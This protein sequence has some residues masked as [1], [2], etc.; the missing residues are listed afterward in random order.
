MCVCVCV[1]KQTYIYGGR[2]GG[3]GSKK[4]KFGL[5]FPNFRRL[6]SLGGLFLIHVVE[7]R[8]W[9]VCGLT[10]ACVFQESGESQVQRDAETECKVV[11]SCMYSQPPGVRGERETL[12]KRN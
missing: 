4:N 7:R 3:G 8:G 6:P 2:G 1:C 10:M 12:S 11:E 5:Q 9:V